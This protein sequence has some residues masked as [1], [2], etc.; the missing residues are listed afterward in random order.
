VIPKAK[1]LDAFCGMSSLRRVGTWH[2][3]MPRHEQAIGQAMAG[4][5]QREK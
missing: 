2:E 1:I 5:R 3:L 4:I